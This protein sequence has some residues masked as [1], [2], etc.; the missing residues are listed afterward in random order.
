MIALHPQPWTDQVSAW[1]LERLW[2]YPNT[3]IPKR[4]AES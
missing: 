1:W 4:V 2:E 3:L